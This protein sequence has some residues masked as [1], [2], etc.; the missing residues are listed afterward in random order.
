MTAN[1]KQMLEIMDLQNYSDDE[2]E[3]L[4]DLDLVKKEQTRLLRRAEQGNTKCLLELRDMEDE[5]QMLRKL[6]EA[7]YA[8]VR[9]ME[10]VEAPLFGR[11]TRCGCKSLEEASAKIQAYQLQT[12][13]MLERIR[14]TRKDVSALEYHSLEKLPLVFAYDADYLLD[15]KERAT[16]RNGAKT[17]SS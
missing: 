11:F 12:N 17:V 15:S 1:L 8:V 2:E 3:D 13:D 7:Q 4:A 9:E 10:Q 6:F 16:V 5:L 14:T